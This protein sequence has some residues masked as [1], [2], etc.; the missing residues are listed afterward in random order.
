MI[1][2]FGLT[3][4]LNGWGVLI[5]LALFFCG[6]FALDQV[7]PALFDGALA[8]AWFGAFAV[9]GLWTMYFVTGQQ[10]R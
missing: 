1:P 4:L 6:A 7:R 2:D 10:K 9:L 5:P 3:N 8:F